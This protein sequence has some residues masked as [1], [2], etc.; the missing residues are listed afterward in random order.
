MVRRKYLFS[1]SVCYLLVCNSFISELTNPLEILTKLINNTT[2]YLLIHRQFFSDETNFSE[3]T[4]YAGLSTIRA[5]VS[6]NEFIGLLNNHE[7]IN[8]SKNEWGDTILIKKK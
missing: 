8:H 5:H 7:I 6:Y 2:S 1:I 3:Y 4:T